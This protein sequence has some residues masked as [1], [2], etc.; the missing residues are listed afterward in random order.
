[1]KP[2][3]QNYDEALIT[4]SAS[5]QSNETLLNQL[6]LEAQSKLLEDILLGT[7]SDVFIAYLRRQQGATVLTRLM[8][9]QELA[10]D[11]LCRQDKAWLNS[12]HQTIAGLFK[13]HYLKKDS[14]GSVQ[15]YSRINLMVDRC[16]GGLTEPF[17]KKC[18]EEDADA[19]HSQPLIETELYILIAKL[20][21]A[22]SVALDA[23]ADFWKKVK[24]SVKEK[25]WLIA[26]LCY[27]YRTRKFGAFIQRLVSFDEIMNGGEYDTANLEEVSD[28][29]ILY[30]RQAL[31]QNLTN[32]DEE[33]LSWYISFERN[34]KSEVLR[35]LIEEA[36]DAKAMEAVKKAIRQYAVASQDSGREKS[37]KDQLADIEK[38]IDK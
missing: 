5:A 21:Q 13:T 12:H 31:Y 3:H 26:V 16:K 7:A 33:N 8:L 34:M 17:L 19:L 29:T 37:H 6:S 11:W 18:L 2:K 30:I 28:Y 36:M 4:L 14:H 20:E 27:I 25:P 32:G 10:F 38:N 22:N 9:G 1:M 24:A 15:C 23:D 35:A